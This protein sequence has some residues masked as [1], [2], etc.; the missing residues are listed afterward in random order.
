MSRWLATWRVS[1][2]RT[3]ADW[4]IVLA[5]WL[6]TLLA[7][8]LLASGPIYADA[9]SEAGLRRSLLDAPAADRNIRVALYAA[10]SEA[11]AANA[12]VAAELAPIVAP[13]NGSLVGEWRGSQTLAMPDVPGVAPGDQALVGAIDDPSANLSLVSGGWPRERADPAGPIEVVIADTVAR[14]LRLEVGD[15]LGLVA[16]PSSDPVEVPI[17]VVGIVTME[18]PE[19]FWYGDEQLLTGVYDNGRYRSFGPFLMTRSDLLHEAE[20]SSVQLR[21]AIARDYAGISADDAAR[22]R[23]RLSGLAERLTA[24]VGGSVGVATGLGSL[25]DQAERSLLVSRTGVLLLMAQLGILAAYA[26]VLT[27][28]LLVEHRRVET[29]LLRSRGASAGKVAGITLL[30]GLLVAAPSVVVA[31]WLAVAALELL[32][33]A[34]P[35]ADSGL[36][37]RPR[38]TAESHVAA[39]IAG[40]LAAVLLALPAALAARAFAVEHGSLARQPTRTISQRLGID[41]ALL[42]IT[43]IALWQL[44]LYGAPLTRTVEGQLGL[45]PLLVAAPAIGLL[46]GGVVALRRLPLLAE[47]LELAVS[48]GRGLV[49]AM[50]ARQLARRPLRYTRSGLLL[51]LA[52]SMGVFALSYGSTWSGSQ[53]DQGT[54]QAGADVRVV[55]STSRTSLPT[56]ALPDAYA[57]LPGVEQVVAVARLPK[58][59]SFAAA[60]AAALLA[61]DA[62]SAAD[63]IAFRPDGAIQPLA[64]LLAGLQAGRPDSSLMTLP[65]GAA[66]LRV[67]PDVEAVRGDPFADPALAE[68]P[69][70]PVPLGDIQ[71]R[72]S[73][74]VVDGRGLVY[75]VESE[76]R[77]AAATDGVVVALVPVDRNRI[78]SAAGG[79]TSLV[80]PVRLA[81]LGLEIWLPPST[82]GTRI[83]I[84]E[85]WVSPDAGGPWIQ[86]VLEDAGP[87]QARIGRDRGVLVDVPVVQTSGTTVE[88]SA[89]GQADFM[90][91]FDPNRP[92][93]RLSVLPASILPLTESVPALV[94]R[95][96]AEAIDVAAGEA[97][98]GTVQG[99]RRRFR[100][101]DVVERFPTTDPQLPLLIIDEPT[102]GL[103]RLQG[104]GAAKPFSELWLGTRAGQEEAV[105]AAARGEPFESRDIVSAGARVRTLSNDPVAIGVIGALAL[106]S[107]ATGLFA[108]VGLVVSTAVSARQ[109]RVEFALLRALGLSDRQLAGSLWLENLSV[110]IVGLAAGTS[111]GLLI[112]WLVLPFI[113]VTQGGSPPVPSVE[114]YTPW[115]EIMVLNLVTG[116]ALAIAVVAAG[117]MLRRLGMGSVLRMGED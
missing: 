42:A 112:A 27:A 25:L 94:N 35:L 105:A 31:P 15:E 32:N 20:L 22:L 36:Q 85:A 12:A 33:V 59:I 56:W 106:G 73:G 19:R 108:V 57:R 9:A 104:T 63:V 7:A 75:R 84:A 80:G 116:L 98:T 96:F 5:A 11:E 47:G 78:G 49:A 41:V 79:S 16:H 81:E 65:D 101:V 28:T 44:R 6:V 52:V 99:A 69:I 62:R 8:V 88:L 21:L 3:R 77:S 58:G 53:R 92:T 76:L 61:L 68:V 95:A 40:L 50:G 43:G 115:I 10:T 24:I 72:A 87:W 67:A 74:H 89:T 34:G 83:G 39:G 30:E 18:P 100:I 55:P 102:L 48:R 51:M 91:S 110:V 2:R 38:V 60:G 26:V 90:Y 66:Y 117:R 29:A 97:I 103:L 46:S 23:N 109:R 107:L 70:E 45:D 111:L 114:I 1:L 86:L 71:V 37:I 113:T 54:Y 4:P 93:G 82:F 13:A 14:A 17:T 64:D